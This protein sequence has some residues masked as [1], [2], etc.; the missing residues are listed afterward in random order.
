MNV[1]RITP[2]LIVDAIEPL[3]PF[4]AERLHFTKTVE[5][6]HEAHLGFV[7]LEKGE[8]QVMLQ[9][10]A[11]L[12][13]DLP[14]LAKLGATSFLYADVDSIEA[15]QRAMQGAEILVPL[16]QTPYGAREIF[17]LTGAQV[18]G[19]AQQG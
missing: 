19:F 16:R 2:V 5:V 7:I 18:I 1:K 6:P 3:L 17:V 9:T 13:V 14:A 8:E 10:K 15:A 12:A 4:W 11:S